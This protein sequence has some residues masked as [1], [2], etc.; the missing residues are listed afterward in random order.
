[1]GGKNLINVSL[2]PEL[3]SAKDAY[4]VDRVENVGVLRFIREYIDGGVMYQFVGSKFDGETIL[5]NSYDIRQGVHLF[6]V[7]SEF[8]PEDRKNKNAFYIVSGNHDTRGDYAYGFIYAPSKEDLLKLA[9]TERE[10]KEYYVVDDYLNVR[11]EVRVPS[12]NEKLCGKAFE[13][14]DEALKYFEG[15]RDS[16]QKEVN[17]ALSELET[18]KKGLNSLIPNGIEPRGDG[19]WKEISAKRCNL[20]DEYYYYCGEDERGKEEWRG[21]FK[22][23]NIDVENDLVTFSNGTCSCLKAKVVKRKEYESY[24]NGKKYSKLR[25]AMK[26]LD[27]GVFS[28]ECENKSL[29]RSF[30]EGG[31][32]I[33]RYNL[34]TFAKYVSEIRNKWLKDKK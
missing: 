16:Y 26:L 25:D 3:T 29:K 27:Q 4:W 10:L 18:C 11:R 15:L 12:D 14:K 5:I 33:T 19:E 31:C 2:I 7:K 21:P 32:N 20:T 13:S 24:K 22:V 28:A 23:T 8:V 6:M 34:R 1:M 9:H 17:S 30:D